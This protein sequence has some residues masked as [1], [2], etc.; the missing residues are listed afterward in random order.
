MII[1]SL[2]KFLNLSLEVN[3]MQDLKNDCIYHAIEKIEEIQE[4]LF[5]NNNNNLFQLIKDEY[6]TYKIFKIN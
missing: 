6:P 2:S 3:S 4:D 1:L 5:N